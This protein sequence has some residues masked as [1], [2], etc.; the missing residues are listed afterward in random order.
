MPELRLKSDEL[1]ELFTEA[2]LTPYKMYSKGPLTTCK[3][4]FPHICY[5]CG[6][7]IPYYKSKTTHFNKEQNPS[8]KYFCSK[9][10][11]DDWMDL[12]S[13]ENYDPALNK[14]E[15]IKVYGQN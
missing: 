10:C 3:A 1:K 2:L 5:L 4:Y 6:K 13:K 12:V 8:K 14:N 7:S 11:R 9:S 15:M